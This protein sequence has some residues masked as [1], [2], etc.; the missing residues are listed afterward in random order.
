MNGSYNIIRKEFGNDFFQLSD[1]YKE[2]H[3]TKL[4]LFVLM[5]NIPELKL[6]NLVKKDTI[7]LIKSKYNLSYEKIAIILNISKAYVAKIIKGSINAK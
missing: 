3:I 7:L 6:E 4:L 2:V 1:M 5:E